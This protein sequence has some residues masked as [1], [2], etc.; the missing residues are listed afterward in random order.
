MQ[1]N[2]IIGLKQVK[3]L[4]QSKLENILWYQ[5]FL[6]FLHVSMVFRKKKKKEGDMVLLVDEAKI[7]LGSLT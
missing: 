4:T 3:K 2:H 6:F 1:K 5:L 7:F